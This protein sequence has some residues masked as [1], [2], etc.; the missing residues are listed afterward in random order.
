M[1][2]KRNVWAATILVLVIGLTGGAWYQQ[3][4]GTAS[5]VPVHSAIASSHRTLQSVSTMHSA[6]AD[7]PRVTVVR[8][9]RLPAGKEGIALALWHQH[10]VSVGGYTGQ[11][12]TDSVFDL[13]PFGTAR[14]AVH[15]IAT[16]P[17]PTHDAAAGY[18]GSDLYIFGGGQ[19]DSYN[20]VLR[21]H[22]GQVQTLAPLARP[23]SDASAVPWTEGG[24][25]GLVVLGGY[26]GRTFNTTARFYQVQGGVL[27]GQALFRMPAGLRYT[28]VAAD[29]S[30]IC[31][32]GGLTA[33]GQPSPVVYRWR[34]GSGVQMVARLPV[35][36]QKAAAFMDG[37]YLVVAGGY[38]AHRSVQ[39]GIWG[40]RLGD[41]QVR[42]IGQLPVPLAD[43]GYTQM[44]Q[45]GILL[46]GTD[47]QGMN[48]FLYRLTLR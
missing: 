46:G 43:M 17:Q 13:D 2:V 15:Q 4:R 20:T 34:P 16:L 19:A 12:S 48:P 47:E 31:W 10:V 8:G 23:L 40:V 44:G 35:A 32:A 41:G 38:D 21:V 1:P 29:S 6:R 42:R 24:H 39:R 45:M 26:D 33:S 28:A 7:W 37:P 30:E 9:P 5:G 11:Y 22:N 3:H 27:Q 14:S 18:I 36:L 25:R